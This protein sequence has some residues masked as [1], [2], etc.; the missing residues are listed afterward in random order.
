MEFSNPSHFKDLFDMITSII[1]GLVALIGVYYGVQTFLLAKEAK[2]EWI[3]QK[4]HEYDVIIKSNLKSLIETMY[5][6]YDYSKNRTQFIINASNNSRYQTS[7][8]LLLK[9]QYP[10]LMHAINFLNYTLYYKSIYQSKLDKIIDIITPAV[11]GMNNST[12]NELFHDLKD[13]VYEYDNKIEGIQQWI[14]FFHDSSVQNKNIDKK[15]LDQFE[16][17]YIPDLIG[18][19]YEHKLGELRSNVN[20]Y[21]RKGN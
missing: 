3:N 5:L 6:I 16:E 19:L 14:H 11:I 9:T 20:N 2:D 15:Y 1:T 21:L 13:Y 7:Q 10:I 4:N 8:Y 18:L 17:I 12:L